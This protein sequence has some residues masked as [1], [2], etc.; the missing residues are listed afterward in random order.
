MIKNH[1]TSFIPNIVLLAVSSLCLVVYIYFPGAISQ[2]Q[3]AS[4]YNIS[5]LPE[6]IATI[7]IITYLLNTMWAFAG[8]FFYGM[9]CVS[10]GMRLSVSFLQKGRIHDLSMSWAL[11]PTYFLIGNIVF[12]IFFLTFASLGILSTTHSIIV[13]SSG[14]LLGMTQLNKL[15]LSTIRFDS[16]FEKIIFLLCLAILTVSIFQSSAHLSYDASAVYFSTAKLTALKHHIGFYLES[17]FPVSVF[18]SVTQFMPLIQVFGDQ[19]ARMITWAFGTSVIFI[20]IAVSHT[21]G[22]STKARYILPSMILTSTAYLDLMGDGKV[23]LVSS[24]YAITAIYWLIASDEE[25]HP[26]QLLYLLSGVFVGFACITRPY[27][28]FLLG[29]FIFLHITLKFTS[30][31]LS[32][33]QARRKLGW[34]A[35]GAVG[36]A[37]Y[38]LLMNKIILGSP[39]GFLTS[40]RDIDPMNGPWDLKPETIWVYRLLYPLVVTYK[41]SGASLGNITPLI[42]I[43]LFTLTKKEIRTKTSL[44]KDMSQL[45][46]S[47][48]VTLY[49]W[50]I[51]FFTVVEV[52]YVLFLWVLLFI[53]LAEV[54]ERSL[55]V[56]DSII[57]NAVKAWIVVLMVFILVRSIYISVAA[58]SPLDIHGNPQC[59]DNE[60]CGNFAA[61]NRYARPGD[62]VLTLGAYRYYL[63]TDLFAC[64]TDSKDYKALQNTSSQSADAFWDEV[65]RQGYK[66]IAFEDGYVRE[67]IQLRI[68]PNPY[69]TP[70]WIKL[71]LIFGKPDDLKIAYKINVTNPPSNV[72]RNC[73]FND[74]SGA[75]EVQ[76]VN[77]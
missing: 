71:E 10:L 61:I 12:S 66:Y 42:L 75:W 14:F 15:F 54:A 62:R 47:A 5:M 46:I 6:K 67:H 28:V 39:F 34:I 7:R 27:N 36:F 56:S 38:H 16:R 41:N 51:M 59:F 9:S 3:E 64:S 57:R 11:L 18:H 65:Y 63:R 29:V 55:T 70:H 19:S 37:L 24:A 58:Y 69:N 74:E 45:A 49:L 2:T 72:E 23:D 68:I 20:A 8:M 53:P 52:R 35:M 40:T 30:K 44:H 43:F 4:L 73:R 31:Q 25:Q 1:Y 32:F 77:P 76:V 48:G 21:V 13:L 17:S 26:N 33:I 60:V 50:V 22:A